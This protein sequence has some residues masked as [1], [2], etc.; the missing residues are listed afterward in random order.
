MQVKKDGP[1]NIAGLQDDDIVIEVNG[2]NVEN[3]EYEDVVAR[4]Q[5]SGNSLT[6]LVCEEKT[7]QHFCSQNKAVT[8]SMADPL[9]GDHGE[10][11]AYAEIQAT[12]P[13]N[14]LAEP[15]ERVSFL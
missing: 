1:A 9:N 3:E 15:R 2:T 7:Y 11:P 6:L 8:A 14:V 10:P 4:I 13:K 12:E 5:D